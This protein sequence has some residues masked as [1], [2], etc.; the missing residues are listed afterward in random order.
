MKSFKPLFTKVFLFGFIFLEV[1]FVRY[2]WKETEPTT[3]KGALAKV[4]ENYVLRWVNT[5]QSTEVKV[6]SSPLQAIGFARDHLNLK[7]GVNPA[8][9]DLLENIWTRKNMSKHIV[10]WKTINLNMV[11]RLTFNDEHHANVFVSAFKRGSYSPSPVGH[12]IY[13]VK[14]SAH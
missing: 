11:H 12:A 9:N 4:G 6:F 5:D 7:P 1:C 14:A 3:Q 2:I 8:S 13:F 10:F